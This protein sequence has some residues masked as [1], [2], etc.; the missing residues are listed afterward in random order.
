MKKIYSLLCAALAAAAM[1]SSCSEDEPFATAGPD[2]DPRIISPVFPDRQN[3]E[4]PIVAN[5]NRD[6]DLEMALTVTPGDYTTPEWFIDGEKLEGV[7]DSLKTQLL[8]GTYTLKIVV[9]TVTGKS[10]S[11]EGLVKVNPLPDDPQTTTVSFERIVAAGEKARLYG[12]NLDRVKGLKI[13]GTAMNN[14]AYNV[15]D[16]C[17]EYTVNASLKDGTYRAVLTGADGQEY[18]A[19]KV[20]VS[21]MPVVTSGADRAMAGSTWTLHGV[22]LD[23][24][25]SLTIGDKTVSTFTEQSAT[26]LSLTF[27]ALAVGD[28]KVTGKT[29]DG[30]SV[31]FYTAAGTVNEQTVTVSEETTLWTG[32]HYVSWDKPDGDANKMFNQLQNEIGKLSAGSTITVHYSIEPSDSYHKIR[33][34]TAWWNEIYPETEVFSNGEISL[35][36]TQDILNK[37][38]SEDGFIIVGHG[39][40]VDLVTVK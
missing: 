26:T 1:L 24:I 9:T 14:V 29:R 27:P 7:T 11:R 19:D 32:H 25:A 4:L 34:A 12:K 23:K 39:F 37:I 6:K 28:Y 8:A 38:N 15:A 40:Y 20:T 17:L 36:L 33:L 31:T 16:D 35:T 13:G 22:N 21:S 3:G 10:T 30:A 5:I 2:D 18:G